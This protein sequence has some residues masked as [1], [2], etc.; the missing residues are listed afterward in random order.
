MSP[1]QGQSRTTRR[2]DV[3]DFPPV[4]RYDLLEAEEDPN[5]ES[6]EDSDPGYDI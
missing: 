4:Q 5:V 6:A 3:I 2:S 1:Q